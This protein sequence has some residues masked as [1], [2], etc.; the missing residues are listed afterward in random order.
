MSLRAAVGAHGAPRVGAQVSQ[1]RSAL[2]LRTVLPQLGPSQR[3]LQGRAV[4]DEWMMQ[5][6]R[7]AAAR[8]GVET[9]CSSSRGS[10]LAATRGHVLVGEPLPVVGAEASLGPACA[11]AAA[12]GVL[13]PR[14]LRA[15]ALI[16][17]VL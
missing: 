17:H 1:G 6:T 13:P 3:L 16:Q 8:V 5:A 15:G 7:D 12:G 9:R 11:A 14:Q 2:G 10:H 4:Q